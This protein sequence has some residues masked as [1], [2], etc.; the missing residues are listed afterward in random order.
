MS[1][2]QI[3]AAHLNG[4]MLDLSKLVGEAVDALQE[5]G[6]EAPE[7][8][9]EYERAYFTTYE[10]QPTDESVAARDKVA[11][12]QTIDQREAK[13]RAANKLKRCE[14]VLKARMA[15]LS[16]LQSV[17]SSVREE[18]KFDRTGGNL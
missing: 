9:A 10:Q 8:R 15:Q 7:K 13:E 6:D 12:A 14:A 1:R 18:A 5:A 16:A 3:T 17:A 11:T 4:W 2:G